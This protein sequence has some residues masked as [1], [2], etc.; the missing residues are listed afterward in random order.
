ML[1]L[2]EKTT[3]THYPQHLSALRAAAD[4]A[5]GELTKLERQR[6][7]ARWWFDPRVSFPWPRSELAMFL[8]AIGDDH[9]QPPTLGPSAFPNLV[10]VSI[11]T[12]WNGY[13]G[14]RPHR[15]YP[16]VALEEPRP[17]FFV[18]GP[19]SIQTILALD[20]LHDTLLFARDINEPLTAPMRAL[21]V[22]AGQIVVFDARLPHR[23][24]PNKGE[25]CTTLL[26]T[27]AT[28]DVPI[29]R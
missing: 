11:N 4:E 25:R 24:G 23:G 20:D 22:R 28:S 5:L 13:E 27:F 15:D 21:D 8:P 19:K 2:H 16:Y 12:T 1:F 26:M 9:D 3:Y 7:S 18:E 29:M 6:C 14:G 10:S 17:H